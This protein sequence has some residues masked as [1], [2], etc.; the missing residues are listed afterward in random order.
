[1]SEVLSRVTAADYLQLMRSMSNMRGNARAIVENL[2]TIRNDLSSND[3]VAW[4]CQEL[5]LQDVQL[6][7]DLNAR[8]NPSESYFHRVYIDELAQGDGFWQTT[9]PDRANE[10]GMTFDYRMVMPTL[11]T[12][13]TVR[14]TLMKLTAPL[15]FETGQFRTELLNW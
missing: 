9:F 4:Y 8:L 3:T 1:M 11:L 7:T 13:M 12:L 5:M 15:F 14:L 10:N 6:R 2:Q